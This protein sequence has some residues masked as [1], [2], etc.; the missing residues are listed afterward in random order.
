MIYLN[1]FLYTSAPVHTAARGGSIWP[2]QD[3]GDAG[4]GKS[5]PLCAN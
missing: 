4:R 3:C 1:I 5:G 2:R